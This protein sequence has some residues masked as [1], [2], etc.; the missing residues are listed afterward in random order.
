MAKFGSDWLPPYGKKIPA[1]L[2]V[3]YRT[4]DEHRD[5][6][7]NVYPRGTPCRALRSPSGEL[8]LLFWNLDRAFEM[9]VEMVAVW[10]PPGAGLCGV[11]PNV[12]DPLLEN[13]A[14]VNL[15]IAGVDARVMHEIRQ[16][17][18][19]EAKERGEREDSILEV[20]TAR[21][22]EDLDRETCA[23]LES[24]PEVPA[25]RASTVVEQEDDG[26]H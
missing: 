6:H 16:D 25:G 3:N 11:E 2:V 4:H 8:C 19:K 22:A 1:G 10:P 18:E 15:V 14:Y 5:R 12:C 17:C 7:G 24:L 21:A 20:A 26:E 13:Q 23:T 9:V